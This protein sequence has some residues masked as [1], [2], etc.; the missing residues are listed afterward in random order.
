MT[1]SDTVNM[2]SVYQFKLPCWHTCS[3]SERAFERVMGP[4]KEH[5]H[6]LHTVMTFSLKSIA[7]DVQTT[8]QLL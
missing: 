8:S 6:A 7:T 1:F 2:D 4:E 3:Q 5:G